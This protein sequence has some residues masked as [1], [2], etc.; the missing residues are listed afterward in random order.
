M[1][2][3]FKYKLQQYRNQVHISS[4]LNDASSFKFNEGDFY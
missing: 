1:R 2:I 4:Y 3:C